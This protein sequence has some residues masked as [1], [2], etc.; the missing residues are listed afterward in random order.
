MDNVI[1]SATTTY[2]GAIKRNDF[3][4]GVNDTL[5]YGPTSA[6]DF[7][8]GIVPPSGG[9]TVYQQKSSNGPSIRVAQND[10]DLIGIAKQYG[11]TNINTVYDALSY[12]NGQPNYLVTNINYPSIVTSGLTLMNDTAYV[13][14]YPKTGT[15][16][17]DLSSYNNN[18]TLS[19]GVTYNSINGGVFLFNGISG[20]VSV[21]ET[22]SID[23]I[24]NTISFGGWC[25]PTTTG[26]FLH[27]IAKNTGLSRQYGMW[28]YLNSQ[29]Q[30]YRALNGVVGQ[31]GV[32]I[33][34]PWSLNAWNYIMLV[35]NGSTIKIY[36]NGNEVSSQN[37]TGNITHTN[38]NVNIGGEPGNAYTFEG[39]ISSTQIYNRALSAAEILQNFNALKSRYGL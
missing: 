3:L 30:I 22:S 1:K 38:S 27:I 14:S 7:W 25:Y 13:P 11:G 5:S 29:I 39:R 28:L 31:T 12:F 36:L 9:Y 6:T 17:N 21:P 19:S 20:Y 10:N 34:S 8:N 37:A 35:Y 2:N 15:T 23:I 18:G 4:I 32:I 26:N 16:F 33:S 24:T